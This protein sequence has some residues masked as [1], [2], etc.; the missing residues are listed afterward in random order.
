[1][2]L[3]PPPG[4]VI[5][6]IVGTTFETPAG[7]SVVSSMKKNPKPERVIVVACGGPFFR[8]RRRTR[9]KSEEARYSPCRHWWA[10]DSYAAEPG[11]IAYMKPGRGRRL[12]WKD[13]KYL[14][15]KNDDI[16]GVA[17]TF[18]SR[19][20]ATHDNV[21]VTPHYEQEFEGILVP[22]EHA[23]RFADFHG[24]T[25]SV[26]PDAERLF[27]THKRSGEKVAFVR[28]EGWPFTHNGVKYLAVRPRWI[29]GFIEEAC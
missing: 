6:E 13:K 25:V 26:G 9:K 16:V 10:S 7:L 27:F 11:Q 28:H 12:E 19:I 29:M 5:G 8:Q 20:Q 24:E 22:D 4:H 17:D 2:S 21:I 3:K 14:C 1:M 18:E 15:L 23:Q